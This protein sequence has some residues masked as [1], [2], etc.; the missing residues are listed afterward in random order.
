MKQYTTRHIMPEKLADYE[1]LE[2]WPD[3]SDE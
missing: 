1:S 2:E 3:D